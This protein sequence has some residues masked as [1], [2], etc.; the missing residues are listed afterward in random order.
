VGARS[1]SLCAP[2][3]HIYKSAE[4]CCRLADCDSPAVDGSEGD[5]G[6]NGSLRGSKDVCLPGRNIRAVLD[7]GG[8]ASSAPFYRA[9]SP[10]ALLLG[11]GPEERVSTVHQF[12]RSAISGT[13]GRK[14]VLISCALAV[15][16]PYVAL[17]QQSGTGKRPHKGS[18]RTAPV[19]ELPVQSPAQS[20]PLAPPPVLTPEQLPPMA[21]QVNW[22]GAQLSISTRNSTLGA[23]LDAVGN[24]TGAY[25][26]MPAGA[27]SERIAVQLGPGPA[28]EV[29]SML[30]SGTDFDYVV[31][32]SDTDSLAVQGIFLTKRSKPGSGAPDRKANTFTAREKYLNGA[33]LPNG[34]T[35]QPE[36][37]PE[38]STS[39]ADAI[40]SRNT[41]DEKAGSTD[42]DAGAARTDV[43][44]AA[45]AP[46][47]DVVAADAKSSSAETAAAPDVAAAQTDP[48]TAPSQP[49]E[50][51][52]ASA[53][54]QKILDMQS[55]F[56][57][58]KQ[59]QEQAAKGKGNN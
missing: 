28:R 40:D 32:A 41:P 26:D 33:N 25:I 12:M 10:P 34:R 24:Q 1:E 11:S 14:L 3:S 7:V 46:T 51:A 52:Q 48:A 27:A 59:M 39:L 31:Q 6:G 29:L 2:A 49:S 43:S 9:E 35:G 30:L 57:Q 42:K 37:Q 4:F 54:Q 16:S 22:D 58:R 8:S 19:I 20:F 53:F 55:L 36:E 47:P 50:T 45:E 21:P 44:S 18:R 17:G 15:L 56:E 38:A 23:V 13:P 5:A